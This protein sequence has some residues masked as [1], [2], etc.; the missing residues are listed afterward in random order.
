MELKALCRVKVPFADLSSQKAPELRMSL[1]QANLLHSNLK[2]SSSAFAIVLIQFF[3]L[4]FSTVESSELLGQRTTLSRKN[5]LA[6]IVD[7]YFPLIV[8]T[9]K[10]REPI[11]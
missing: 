4:T 10:A 11:N 3:W 6:K 7:S 5:V 2:Q 8:L 9:E 1:K